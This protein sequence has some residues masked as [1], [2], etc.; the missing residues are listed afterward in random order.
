MLSPIFNFTSN[1]GAEVS[2]G[3]KTFVEMQN[4]YSI[5]KHIVFFFG[6]IS[7]FDNK[8]GGKI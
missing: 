4:L 2:T 8:G 3:S 6:K 5:H 7:D 1:T